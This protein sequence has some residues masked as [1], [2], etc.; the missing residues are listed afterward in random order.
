[1][2]MGAATSIRLEHRPGNIGQFAVAV[3]AVPSVDIAAAGVDTDRLLAVVELD[4]PPFPLARSS[5]RVV[6]Y[7]TDL[8]PSGSAATSPLRGV[9]GIHQ[10]L[11]PD[12][13]HRQRHPDRQGR[14]QRLDIV[15]VRGCG[16]Q[17]RWPF[18][19]QGEGLPY[20]AS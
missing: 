5:R 13:R 20:Y 10:V 18:Y 11:A 9:V 1:M 19:A 16:A 8:A 6:R 17:L 4:Q 7:P 2:R 3:S 12:R 15:D 14:R